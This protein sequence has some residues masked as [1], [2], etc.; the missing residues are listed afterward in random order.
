MQNEI[1]VYRQNVPLPTLETTT[2]VLSSAASLQSIDQGL[3]LK[4]ICKNRYTSRR[5]HFADCYFFSFRWL[6]PEEHWVID[7]R[8]Q[9]FWPARNLVKILYLRGIMDKL[10][11]PLV[12]AGKELKFQ[13]QEGH[14]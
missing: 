6:E 8:R 11:K 4:E 10:G 12:N 14:V 5:K 7:R 13:R 2:P 3:K 9:W 1:Y